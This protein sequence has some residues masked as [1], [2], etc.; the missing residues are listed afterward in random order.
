MKHYIDQDGVVYAYEL[1]GSQ[2]HLI[3]DKTPIEGDA[4]AAAIDAAAKKAEAIMAA[5][6]QA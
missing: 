3:G 1:D 2:D 5:R 6:K 4:L